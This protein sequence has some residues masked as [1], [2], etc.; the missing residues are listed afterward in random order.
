MFKYF[1]ELLYVANRVHAFYFGL[2]KGGI[3][4]SGSIESLRLG[5]LLVNLDHERL[6]NNLYR[7]VTF[8]FERNPMKFTLL[9]ES[10]IYTNVSSIRFTRF[11]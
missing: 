11:A 3:L 6:Y 2:H 7:S 4:M 1:C 9:F 8:S 5:L 10:C